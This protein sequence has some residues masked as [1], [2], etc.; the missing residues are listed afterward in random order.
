L[1][2]DDLLIEADRLNITVKEIDMIGYGG[3]CY[4]D[5]IAINKALDTDNKKMCVLAEELGHY[6]MTAGDITDQCRV[7]N[8]KQELLARKWGYE[9]IVSL[10]GLIEAFEYGARD[11][12]ETSEFLGVTEEYLQDCIESYKRKYGFMHQIEPYIIYFEPSLTIGKSFNQ[13]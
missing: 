2:Y 1:S 3:F 5:L 10:V 4:G 11:P 7:E 12:F 8:R 6:I 13:F 9:H